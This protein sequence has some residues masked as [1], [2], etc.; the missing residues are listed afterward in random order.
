MDNNQLDEHIRNALQQNVVGIEAD[1]SCLT[2]IKGALH[3]QNE[4]DRSA[5][6][7]NQPLNWVINKPVT[8]IASF[9]IIV[10]LTCTLVQPVRVIAKDCIIN[11]YRLIIGESGQPEVVQVPVERSSITRSSLKSITENEQE[12]EVGF[13]VKAPQSLFGGYQLE[14]TVVSQTD[15]TNIKQLIKYYSKDDSTLVLNI[16][17]LDY[18]IQTSVIQEN[19]KELNINEQVAYYYEEPQAVYPIVEQ[20]GNLSNDLTQPPTEIKRVR[21]LAWEYAGT[22]YCLTDMGNGINIDV[23]TSIA[24]SVISYQGS[25]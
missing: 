25:K 8:L 14:E 20:D 9:A 21:Y 1:T 5:S 12:R 15:G 4:G 11:I 24:E 13:A 16:T 19:R 2:C 22:Y 3:Q 17:K 18:P 10:V 7:R 23:L 6:K